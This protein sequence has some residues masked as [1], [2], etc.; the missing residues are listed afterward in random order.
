MAVGG[1]NLLVAFGGAPLFLLQVI[2]VFKGI[3]PP[4][5]PSPLTIFRH[6]PG[7]GASYEPPAGEFPDLAFGTAGHSNRHHIGI[8]KVDFEI[9]YC[10]F[11][12]GEPCFAGVHGGSQ[13]GYFALAHLSPGQLAS[14]CIAVLAGGSLAEYL[15]GSGP[16]P[17]V[18]TDGAIPVFPLRFRLQAARIVQEFYTRVGTKARPGKSR[19]LNRPSLWLRSLP[20]LGLLF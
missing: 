16:P 11:P 20:R 4:R 17:T 7:A 18:Y 19:S 8:S 14:I 10:Q 2:A 6:V 13:A 1:H 3:P 9:W 12:S 5:P 15:A